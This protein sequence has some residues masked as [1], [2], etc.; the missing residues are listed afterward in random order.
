MPKTSKMAEPL[1]NPW[2]RSGTVAFSQ[3]IR[4]PFNQ[5]LPFS[6]I[7]LSFL[8]LCAH[9]QFRWFVGHSEYRPQQEASG[10]PREGPSLGNSRRTLPNRNLNINRWHGSHRSLHSRMPPI[11][12]KFNTLRPFLTSQYP[13]HGILGYVYLQRQKRG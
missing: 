1:E 13:E 2:D 4:S 8:S 5:T 12:P 10:C 6:L 9:D 7:I 11:R 3:G